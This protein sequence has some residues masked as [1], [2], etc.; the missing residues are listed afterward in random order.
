MSAESLEWSKAAETAPTENIES[1]RKESM[2]EVASSHQIDL[3]DLKKLDIDRTEDRTS[4]RGTVGK[5][6]VSL[7]LTS[8]GVQGTQGDR[9][10]S[11]H[12]AEIEYLKLSHAI[13]QRDA[14]NDKAVEQ[15]RYVINEHH[16]LSQD[17]RKK[18][19]L[20]EGVESRGEKHV[21]EAGNI[22]F[23]S[24]SVP[25]TTELVEI[26]GGGLRLGIEAAEKIGGVSYA[27]VPF[28]IECRK[29]DY[30]PERI[31]VTVLFP[32]E[33]ITPGGNFKE[34]AR[35]IR[36]FGSK[37]FLVPAGIWEPSDK[38]SFAHWTLKH[39]L[40]LYVRSELENYLK[41]PG[42]NRTMGGFRV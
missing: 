36:D 5:E 7:T 17:L 21:L 29:G 32:T 33:K 16:R 27:E 18:P 30:G 26:L 38:V 25:L 31:R 24:D 8:E 10:L 11:P 19:R 42:W 4:I 41:D 13:N 2:E 37:G 14:A 40:S 28:I 15:T 12:E 6:S 3:Q 22:I 20:A 9:P 23:Q 35:H 1:S 34:G 39:L